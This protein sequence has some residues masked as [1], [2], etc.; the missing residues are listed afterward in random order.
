[1]RLNHKPYVAVVQATGTKEAP[2]FRI[3]A[4]GPEEAILSEVKRIFG[5]EHQLHAV[6]DHFAQT[7][8][9]PILNVISERRLCW[10]SIYIIA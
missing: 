5:M 9:A 10:I 4:N 8:L 6:H 1:M 3:Q 7:N 2:S